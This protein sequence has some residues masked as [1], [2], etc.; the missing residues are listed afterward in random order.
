MF[1]LGGRF[2]KELLKWAFYGFPQRSDARIRELFT[3]CNYCPELD[4]YEDGKGICSICGCNI[5]RDERRMNKLAW[6]TTR[7]P[8]DPPRWV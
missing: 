5:K 7:C 4:K 6:G 8:D 2:L 3:I 1:K